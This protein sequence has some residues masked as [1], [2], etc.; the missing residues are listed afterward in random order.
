[1]AGSWAKRVMPQSVCCSTGPLFSN[2]GRRSQHKGGHRSPRGGCPR[3]RCAPGR[4]RTAGL[5]ANIRPTPAPPSRRPGLALC[6]SRVGFRCWR[7]SCRRDVDDYTTTAF[8]IRRFEF[9]RRLLPADN[10]RVNT[11]SAGAAVIKCH[12]SLPLTRQFCAGVIVGL[13]AL[14]KREPVRAT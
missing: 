13:L 3:R 8:T 5:V 7:S 10:R 12:L 11:E 1:M 6:C 14:G 4:S 9:R 2:T